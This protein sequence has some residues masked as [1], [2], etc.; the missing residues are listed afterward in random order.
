[1]PC[2]HPALRPRAAGSTTPMLGAR[3]RRG[4]ALSAL[5]LAA[6]A[7]VASAQTVPDPLALPSSARDCASA[8]ASSS[9][10][11]PATLRA[12]LRCVIDVERTSRGLSPLPADAHVDTA[13]AGHARDMVRRHYFAHQRAGGPSPKQRMRRAGWRGHRTGEAIAWGCGS[14]GTPLATV[15]AWLNSPPHRAILLDA[16]WRGAGIGVARHA[17][18][19]R[20]A[21]GATWVLDAGR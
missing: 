13:A 16:H 9:S 2:S 8:S 6:A 7:P 19:T 17:P 14:L 20:C 12:A 3:L 5:A 18:V 21:D 4:V 15:R 11:A 10:A 1:M